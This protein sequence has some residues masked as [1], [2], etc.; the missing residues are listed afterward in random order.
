LA[1]F[2]F[3]TLLN[4]TSMFNHSNIHIPEQVDKP[5][6]LF[7]VTPDMHRVHHSIYNDETNRNFGFNL[8]WWDHLFGT[9]Q[10]QPRSGHDQ[11][12][13]GIPAFREPRR[14]T[15]L[16]GILAIPFLRR[17]NDQPTIHQEVSYPAG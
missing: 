6:R 11:M 9:Y 1:V 8:P 12:V 2:I 10:A 15:T 16:L 5:L 7:V 17:S 4:I 14:C 13:I 3:E